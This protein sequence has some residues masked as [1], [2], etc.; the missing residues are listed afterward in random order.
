MSE[1]NTDSW[2]GLLKNFLKADHLKDNEETFACSNVTV[3]DQDMDLILEK[4]E[5]K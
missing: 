4:A 1:T 2:D 5:K 3:T